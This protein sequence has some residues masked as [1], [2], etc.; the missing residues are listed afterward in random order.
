[1]ERYE[2]FSA[3]SKD[4]IKH[5]EI[6]DF[7]EKKGFVEHYY[8][9]DI[10]VGDVLLYVYDNED[11]KI[12]GYAS[13]DLLKKPQSTLYLSKIETFDEEI[14]GVNNRNK[15]IASKLLNYITDFARDNDY[16]CI[17]LAAINKRAES[18]YF[19]HG[20]VTYAKHEHG[21]A[22]M[23]KETNPSF[24]RLSCLL[25][26]ATKEAYEKTTNVETEVNKILKNKWY[27]NL[28]EYNII[29]ENPFNDKY[30]PYITFKI[31]NK[32]IKNDMKEYRELLQDIYPKLDKM[33]I[34]GKGDLKYN[35]HKMA[36][37]VPTSHSIVTNPE[38]I[39]KDRICRNICNLF[40]DDSFNKTEEKQEDKEQEKIQK[41]DNDKKRS[42]VVPLPKGK[43]YI[44]ERN[45]D[46]SKG[47]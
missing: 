4:E 21:W 34:F 33:I 38:I 36:L 20:F 3:T 27:D 31:F 43:S 39:A 47:K 16:E 35:V 18:L 17:Q 32:Q 30:N 45:Y 9:F 26:E 12:V 19:Q 15:G 37:S 1:M 6:I 41:D 22:R 46:I 5:K 11:K 44:I 28:F 7:L 2:I 13:L 10:T 14:V 23:E 25:Y 40:I 24:W 29:E 8:Y 42:I